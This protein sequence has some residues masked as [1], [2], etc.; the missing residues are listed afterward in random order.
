MHFTSPLT[1]PTHSRYFMCISLWGGS[2]W[3]LT[4]QRTSLARLPLSL[5]LSDCPFRTSDSF[6]TGVLWKYV[7]VHKRSCVPIK[8]LSK[9]HFSPKFYR[10][11]FFF[12]SSNWYIGWQ[13]R[14]SKRGLDGLTACLTMAWR[15]S[16]PIA[17]YTAYMAPSSGSRHFKDS[18]FSNR[19][20]PFLQPISSITSESHWEAHS[21]NSPAVLVP[22][23]WE[24]L[25]IDLHSHTCTL[26]GR[27]HSPVCTPFVW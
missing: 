12:Q 22:W 13:Q 7:D 3:A 6:L 4:V 25:S 1:I 10:C 24:A 2:K 19:T 8:Y 11:V 27:Q 20:L 9:N 5:F 17:L 21:S 18:P 15:D 26:S 23:L 16:S 14:F